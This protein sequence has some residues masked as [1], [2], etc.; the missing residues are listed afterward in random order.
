MYLRWGIGTAVGYLE[1]WNRAGTESST[2]WIECTGVMGAAG[3]FGV[4]EFRYDMEE[5][6]DSCCERT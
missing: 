1:G 5:V 4:A 3:L 6:L 2:V